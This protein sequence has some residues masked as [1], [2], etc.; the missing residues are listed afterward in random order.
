MPQIK[1]LGATNIIYSKG[2]VIQTAGGISQ[3]CPELAFTM[4]VKKSFRINNHTFTGMEST[5]N[6]N[7][8]VNMHLQNKVNLI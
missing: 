1:R 2:M 6:L 8:E 5:I 7:Q 4:S 3:P